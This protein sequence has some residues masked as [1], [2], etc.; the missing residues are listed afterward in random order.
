[1]YALKDK[2]PTDAHQDEKPVEPDQQGSHNSESGIHMASQTFER[3]DTDQI[4]QA[5]FE[6][7]PTGTMAPPSS[8]SQVNI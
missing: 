8:I 4:Q 3:I 1:M 5:G 2:P 6:A 7:P